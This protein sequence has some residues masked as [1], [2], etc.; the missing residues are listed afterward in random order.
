MSIRL[1][2]MLLVLG[3]AILPAIFM[4]YRYA[5]DRDERI[6]AAKRDLF[7]V[8]HAIASNLDTG[9]NGTIQLQYGLVQARVLRDGDKTT[10][11]R[12][13]SEVRERNPQYTGILTIDPNGALRCDSLMTGRTL[14]VRD[15]D[16][17]RRA[18]AIASGT[19]IQPTI[20]RL[21]GTPVLQIASP[22]RDEDQR[23][24]FVLLASLDL[25]KFLKEN[26]KT[27]PVGTD[28]FVVSDDGTVM[29]S[30]TRSAARKPGTSL[31][32]SAL[33]KL[34]ADDVNSLQELSDERGETQVWSV[35]G[36]FA[37]DG[38]SLLVLAGRAKS[39]L[40]VAPNKRLAQDLAISIVFCLLLAGAIAVVAE[41][42]ISSPISRI[43][44][45]I[46]RFASGDLGAR[47]AAP[48]PRGE[49]G[50]LIETLNGS[51]EAI[52][53]Q[54]RDIECLKKEAEQ[55][56]ELALLEKNRLHL[57]INNIV[58]GLILFDA[59]GQVIVCN[60]QYRD[61]Y[62]LSANVVKPGLD[63][64][65]LMKHR[66]ETGSFNGDVERFC[67]SVLKHMRKE[68]ST[69]R[70][71]DAVGRRVIQNLRS[72][73]P[74]GGWLTTTEDITERE[75]YVERIL[76][77]AH[78]DSLTELPNRIRFSDQLGMALSELSTNEMLAVLY[79]D[80]DEFK[81]INDSL[82]HTVGD[83]LLKE[84]SRRLRGC[85]TENELVA[86]IGG[87]EFA[88]IQTPIRDRSE[89]A[90]L[91]ERLYAAIRQPFQCQDHMLTA[92]ASI[93]VA[94]APEHGSDIDLLL[95]RADMAMYEAKA[96]G[97]RGA[98][99]FETS[100]EARLKAIRTMER[101]LAVAIVNG[102]FEVHFQP[103]V[104]LADD[105]VVG[106]EALIRWRHPN[107]G[108][109]SP[110]EFIPVAE[111]TGLIEKLGEWVLSKSC[112]EAAT[113][114]QH[115]KVAVNV[116]PVQ[117]RNRAF[118]LKV[119]D[120]LAKSGLS[121]QRLE[122][123]ITEAVLIHDDEVALATLHEI[124]ALG[125]RIAM[126]DFGTGYSSLSYLRRFPFDKIKIDR[127]FIAD[128]DEPNGSACIVKAVLDIAKARNIATTAEG[129]ETSQQRD[130]L[131]EL[132]CT[133]M[134]GYFYSPA[135]PASKA[136]LFLSDALSRK[137]KDSTFVG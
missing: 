90:A 50:T 53:R 75:R 55:S 95:M 1:R 104:R 122:L 76:H 23:L 113:W 126:D 130:R 45:M 87:D 17:F 36:T 60:Q 84:I 74:N 57:A 71:R 37:V 6:E 115:V 56:H 111:E 129:I 61:L 32:G 52:E 123:E 68:T 103:L 131:R 64:V 105:M 93:G 67:A 70:T 110:A 86:R 31:K 119:V 79:I 101:D 134:Q 117:F 47:I 114:P 100:M 78:Y 40:M 13:L 102:E 15:R 120:A 91:I 19:V 5:Q 4:G 94:V 10:C 92:D 9:V 21:T 7:S 54:Q 77:M 121:P 109:V 28:V 39:D 106:F 16:Y 137:K 35:S 49:L 25:N 65:G 26:V 12:F 62:G 58:Q 59:E 98:R 135:V 136:V 132:G 41:L 46:K 108:L 107:R 14:D 27:L 48:Y 44:S 116:S 3:V 88:I 85:L 18:S 118:A 8:A 125:V 11:S 97:R 33:F 22:V 30:A 20:G 43:S 2:L 99:W 112:A 63:L 124:R 66:K 24:L 69:L 81:G 51:A 82:G 96:N 38:K 89:T 127:S 72:P 128:I 80:I 83:E 29:A 133:E 34:I 42:S 73:L